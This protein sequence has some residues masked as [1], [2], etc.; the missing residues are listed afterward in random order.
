MKNNPTIIQLELG[1][2]AN[3]SYII[4]N[5]D[6]G[7]AAVVDPNDDTAAINAAA[8]KEGLTI[9]MI[10]LTH[11]HYDHVGGV[12]YYDERRVPTCLSAQEFPVYVPPCRHLKRITDK[13]II[14]VG[15]LSIECLATPGHTP[16]GMCYLVN[17]NLF[18]GDTLFVNAIG[19]TDFPGGKARDLFNS[20]QRL[21]QLPDNTIIWPGHN[22]GE[23][24][25]APLKALKTGNPYLACASEAEFLRNS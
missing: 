21:K 23:V 7:V 3:F 14:K 15:G 2:M 25:H 16:G 10:L 4:G 18:T 11:G 20:L 12:G 5:K 24:S 19:R 13:E 6:A 8:W 9:T 17:G 22:Y 1:D